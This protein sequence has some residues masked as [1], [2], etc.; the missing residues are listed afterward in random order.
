MDCT[1]L[2]CS[3]LSPRVCSNSCPLSQWCHPTISSSAAPF[4]SFHQSFPASGSFPVSWFFTSGGQSI[5]ASAST[6]ALPMN[7]QGWFPLGLTGLISLLSKRLSRVFSSTTVQKLQF[8]GI[9]LFYGPT[10]TSVHDY[11]KNHSFDYIDFCQQSDVS[12]FNTPSR[13]VIMATHSNTLAWKIPWMEGPGRLQSM[14]LLGVRHDW[15]TSLSLFT[16]MHWRR[17]WQPTP[18]FLPGESQGQGAW[19]AAVYG[20]AQSQIQLKRLSSSSNHI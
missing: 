19:W 15:A 16:F 17:K 5:G 10:I 9:Q 1:R 13:L 20:V 18:V 6:S 7:I 2:P 11:L 12:G 8:L 4:S 14:G 3:S